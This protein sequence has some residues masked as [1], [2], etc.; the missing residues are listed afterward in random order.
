MKDEGHLR[1]TVFKA[2][3]EY[4]VFMNE[5]K[6]KDVTCC[7]QLMVQMETLENTLVD[8]VIELRKAKYEEWK[9]GKKG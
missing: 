2:R 1:R 5:H 7:W 3:R 8:A 6:M 9:G 4:Y